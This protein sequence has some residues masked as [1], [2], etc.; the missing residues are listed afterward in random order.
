VLN[1]QV[2]DQLHD[3]DSLA[4]AGSAKKPYLAALCVGRQE[5]D[6]L[7]ACFKNGRGESKTLEGAFG[8]VKGARGGEK[9]R[10]GLGRA[11]RGRLLS[12][13]VT[14]R[15]RAAVG[16]KLSQSGSA[17]KANAIA[18]KR[19]RDLLRTDAAFAKGVS[20]QKWVECAPRCVDETTE[21]APPN[22]HSRCLKVQPSV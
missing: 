5:I 10:R 13:E 8:R 15:G 11:P 18:P 21:R 19:R 3:H 1:C 9:G 12:R 17:P 4:D 6:D 22:W 16:V 20:V 2:P 7:D 14:R